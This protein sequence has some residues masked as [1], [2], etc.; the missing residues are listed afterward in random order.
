[1]VAHRRWWLAALALAAPSLI[2]TVPVAPSLVAG[3]YAQTLPGARAVPYVVPLVAWLAVAAA[4]AAGRRLLRDGDLVSRAIAIVSVAGVAGG[5]VSVERHV[6]RAGYPALHVGATL[7][8]IVLVGVAVR[9]A[10]RASLPAVIGAAVAALALGTAAASCAYGLAAPADR[11]RLATYGDQTKDLVRVWRAILDFDRDGSSALLG[12]GDCDDFDR[13][14]H[15]GALEIAGDGID[16]DCDGIDPPKPPPPPPPP[17]DAASWRASP[18][19]TALLARTKG[20]NV[21]LITVDAL[22]F[23]PLAPDAPDRADFPRL[24][25]LLDDSVWFVRS[26]A[27][28]SGTDVSLSTI[29]T[30]RFD[31][32]QRVDTTLP[33]ALRAHGYH[34][35]AVIPREVLR[36]VGEVLIGRGEDRVATVR[37]D[38]KK[39][40]VGDHVSADETTTAGLAGIDRPP[41]FL[42]VHYFDVHEHHQID[43]PRALLDAV[44]PG[45]SPVIHKYRA[46]LRAIDTEIGRL[47]DSLDLDHTIVIFASDHGEALA[48]DPRLLDT[49]GVVAYAPLVRIPLAIRVPGVPPARV[50]D[51][52]S[53]VDLAPTVLE[54]V[55]APG[56]IGPLDGT[57]LVPVLLAAPA[58]LRPPADRA[59]AIHEEQQ[60]SVVVWPYQLLVRPADNLTELYEL[61]RDPAEHDDLAARLPDVVTKLRARYAE[62]PPVKVDRTPAGRTVR[63][64]QARRP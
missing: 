62:F 54:L 5:L 37:T 39:Q 42:W 51:P 4:I 19:V 47:V 56:A 30:G 3:A 26:V 8:V 23:G 25:K 12:G 18:A 52:V 48:E 43:V 40:D 38:T 53:L 63:E 36:F 1:L 46:L 41:F 22:R 55:G 33:E 50:M 11:A 29:L 58:A 20:M 57:D 24:T 16:Q 28:A 32:Y 13:S 61:E 2:V 10:W 6:L 31:P 49:H 15:P 34:T 9:V 59:I 35:L 17:A 21:V 7:A 64:Q 14:R 27:P 60:W 45:A 44:H